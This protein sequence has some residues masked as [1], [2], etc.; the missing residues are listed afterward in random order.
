MRTV[1]LFLLVTSLLA[2][3]AWPAPDGAEAYRRA[4]EL[5]RSG[6]AAEAVRLLDEAIA[7]GTRGAAPRLLLGW[8]L[9]RLERFAEAEASFGAAAE[10]EPSV[11]E[12][13][14]GLGFA[15]LRRD[16]VEEAR[17]FFDRALALDAGSADAWKGKGL[18]LQR[19]GD[20]EGAVAAFGRAVQADPADAEAQALLERARSTLPI[21]SERRPRGPVGGTGPPIVEVRARQGRFELLRDGSWE[22]FFVKGLNLG[23]ALPGYYPSEFPDDFALY[24]DWFDQIGELGANVIRLY[25]LHPPS[26][27]R[28]LRAHNEE[29][30]EHKLWLVQGV[31]A[32]LPPGHDFDTPSY[33]EA[34]HAEVRRVIDAVY[35]NLELPARPGSAHGVYDVDLG[36]DLL[37]LLPGREWE[38]FAVDGFQRLRPGPRSFE[39]RYVRTGQVQPMEAWLASLCEVAAA[40]ETEQ[41]GRQH[42]VGFSSW[43]TLDPLR[44]PTESTALEEMKLQGVEIG[45]EHLAREVY[46]EDRIGVDATLLSATENFPAGLFAAYHVYPYYPDFMI[47]EPGY[48]ETRDQ[49]GP[50]RYLGYLRALKRHHGDQPLLIAEFGVPTSRG[51]S[52]LHPEGQHHGGHSGQVQGEIDARMLGNIR[53]AG[54]AGGIVFAW[55][56]EWFK[57]NWIVSNRY[58]PPERVRLWFNVMDP[59]QNFGLLAARPGEAG[60]AIVLD[61]NGADWESVPALY[62]PS[63]EAGEGTGSAPGVIRAFKVTQ[64]EA[65]IYLHLETEGG[66]PLPGDGRTEYW[67]GIDTYDVERGDHRFPPP[68]GLSIPPGLEFLVRIGGKESRI[69]I[70]PPYRIFSGIALRPCRSESNDDGEFVEIVAVPNRERWGRD[71]THFPAQSYSRSP[72]RFGSTDPASPDQHD[73]ADWYAAPDGGVVEARIPWGLLNVSDPSSHRVIHETSRTD[74][75]VESARTEGFRFHVLALRDDGDGPRVVQSLPQGPELTPADYPLFSWPGW[76]KPTY[77]LELKESYFVLQEALRDF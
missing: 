6:E 17:E 44:H 39:G 48:A 16:R 18:A 9:L 5:Y 68:A 55:M 53:D 33:V 74:G 30:P 66:G 1:L 34:L 76:E 11:A 54:M 32:E 69:L 27:Y 56:D 62:E 52:H 42:P 73:L 36:E 4:L 21:R 14:T 43:P 2:G 71:G 35:G 38:P 47:L 3:A 58:A 59:E 25:T 65:Y 75:T 19:A 40:H 13:W 50:S 45:P 31:W 49:Q 20:A 60:W 12:A 64:D 77:H 15:M 24:R 67:I 46:D 22:P 8:C 23:T 7:G 28:A 72:L 26:L 61:G 70:D 29:N 51:I 41:Y 63:R 10:I 57:R 37:L